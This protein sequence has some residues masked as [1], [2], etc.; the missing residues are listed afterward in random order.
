[1]SVFD[2]FKNKKTEKIN[3]YHGLREQ[4]LSIKPA[5]IGVT[6][7][8]NEQVYAAVVDM[9]FPDGRIATLACIYDGTVSLYYSTG[10][11]LLGMGQKYEEVRSAGY[12]F[13]I[14]AGQTLKY[15]KKTDSFGLPLD[16]NAF[17]YLLA[18]DGVYK[19]EFNMSNVGTEEKHNQFL[20]YFIQN[21][22]NKVRENNTNA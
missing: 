12:S 19:T 16:S 8:S 7:D 21:T 2:K 9:P 20:N 13:L 22:L 11:G 6:L 1:M 14:N 17:V 4:A 18:G 10:G 5:D 15:L 3:P